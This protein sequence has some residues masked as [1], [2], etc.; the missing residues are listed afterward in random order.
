MRI[1]DQFLRDGDRLFRWRSYLPIALVP[2]LLAGILTTGVPFES[3]D[4]ER[5][6]EVLAVAVAVA[7]LLLRAWAVGTA[8][9]GTSERSTVNPRASQLRTDGLYSMLRHPLYLANGL[10]GLGIALFPGVWF[11]PVIVALA[12]LL[13]YE[14][15]AA[16]EEQ[17]LEGVF[18][19]TFRAWANRVPAIVPRLDTYVASGSSMSWRKV[20]R[21]EFHGLLV[22]A[23]SVVVLDAAQE[24]QRLHAWSTDPL[25]MWVLVV[26]AGVFAVTQVLKKTTRVLDREDPPC[27]C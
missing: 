19:E 1:L 2:V 17:F 5:V 11:L 27:R 6:W 13:Q 10:M 15:V 8:P 20:V 26:T 14:R 23:A 25:W 21:D 24:W 7:G 18:G 16:R 9:P 12:T 3:R 4:S 22:I